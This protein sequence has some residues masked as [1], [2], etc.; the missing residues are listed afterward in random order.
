M[1]EIF[2]EKFFNVVSGLALGCD[3]SAHKGCLDKLGFTTAVLAHGLDTVYPKENTEIADQ[4]VKSG[5]I[6][7]SEYYVGQTSRPNYFIERDRIQAALSDGIIVV[8]TDQKGGTMHTTG[9]AKEYDKLIGVFKHPDTTKPH[10]MMEGNK[11][12]V[13]EGCVSQ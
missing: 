3:V 7:I 4:I 9:F 6:L 5:G 8:E 11:L 12:L 2:A 13:S 10:R 1:G